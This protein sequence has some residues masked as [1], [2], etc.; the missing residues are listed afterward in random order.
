MANY[1]KCANEAK[2]QGYLAF[3][4]GTT[5][6]YVIQELYSDRFKYPRYYKPIAP[7]FVGVGIGYLLTAYK[8][9]YCD[10]MHFLDMHK[11]KEDDE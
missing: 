9:F 4:A 3:L 7:V 11:K 5:V 8:M 2:T 10:Q 1:D 6:A